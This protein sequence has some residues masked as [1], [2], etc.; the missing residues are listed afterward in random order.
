MR[1]APF[2]IRLFHA[3]RFILLPFD[4][5]AYARLRAFP[6]L[7]CRCLC[8]HMF[9]TIWRAMSR[10]RYRLR[11]FPRACRYVTRYLLACRCLSRVVDCCFICARDYML[12][13]LMM[14]FARAVY[15]LRAAHCLPA[16]RRARYYHGVAKRH[17]MASLMFAMPRRAV[18]PM[19]L[20]A[21]LFFF[22]R[23]WLYAVFALCYL[24]SALFFWF[25]LRCFCRSLCCSPC[26]FFFFAAL[27]FAFAEF[28]LFDAYFRLFILICLI[29]AFISRR[30]DAIVAYALFRFFAMIHYFDMMM[31]F[32]IDA[33][34]AIRY[35]D[36]PALFPA[37]AHADFSC[38]F[39][40]LCRCATGL[41]CAPRLFA[42]RA[43][44]FSHVH[45]IWR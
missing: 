35:F 12:R 32:F 14:F 25:S 17:A 34:S 2:A 7:I 20:Y 31:P 9:A 36:M 10:A 39:A 42:I 13:L 38:C 33:D 1:C 19:T 5:D 44:H 4:I 16:L 11:Y 27:I 18:M 22:F 37:T 29:A 6:I 8:C 28:C 23:Y 21:P 30:F 15:A 40:L 43:C 26:L 3:F 45:I 24:P 41:R